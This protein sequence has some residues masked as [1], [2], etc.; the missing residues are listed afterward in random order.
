MQ[1]SSFDI[2]DT[3]ITRKCKEP[4]DIFKVIEKEYPYPNF[5]N[6]RC[7]AEKNAYDKYLLSTNI[8]N[9]YEEF[10]KLTNEPDDIIILLRQFEIKTELEYSIPIISNINKIRPNDIYISDMYL[11]PEIIYM[12]LKKHNI[13]IDNKLYVSS[14]GKSTGIIYEDLLKSYNIKLHTG[15]NMHSDIIMANR[16][17][18]K[19][20]HTK[21]HDF[22]K[23]ELLLYDLKLFNFQK[24]LRQFRLEN[25]YEEDT[26]YYKLYYEQITYNI[27][28]LVLFSIQ[29]KK[30]LDSEN[31]TKVLFFTR[32]CCLLIKI[33]NKL[34]PSID[35]ISF[36]SSRII[37]YK[38]NIDYMNYVKKHYQCNNSIII[39]LH[40]SFWSGRELYTTIFGIL[41]RVHLLVYDNFKP[42]F[43]NLTY[44]IDNKKLSNMFGSEYIESM[45]YDLTGTLFSMINDEELRF[46]NEHDETNIN[47][48]HNA[49]L[50]F[51]E[52]NYDFSEIEQLD[53]ISEL[54]V[55][56]Y[57]NIS[58]DTCIKNIHI[59][60]LN[61]SKKIEKIMVS[62]HN[63]IS[64]DSIL[65]NIPT[66]KNTMKMNI[67]DFNK[68]INKTTKINKP[69]NMKIN[70]TEPFP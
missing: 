56:I 32:D 64:N 31:R 10:K 41:P 70:Y 55:S 39:D 30:I 4:C 38:K 27:P 8:D 7:L 40:G 19:T 48:S 58:T 28:L 16:Y 68:N 12:L 20:F 25:P 5:F 44:E 1:I 23:T 69:I 43:N 22:T 67:I 26:L 15:D 45:N 54:L 52:K 2:F 3:L 13:N 65:Q 37:H 34:F 46:H 29:I 66:K 35:A 59:P 11:T 9:I 24:L 57:K 49:V 36:S 53:N 61:I 50:S 33:F 18:I 60:P 14:G 47:I 62:G 17:N 6:I 21:I 42:G 63:I 51:L